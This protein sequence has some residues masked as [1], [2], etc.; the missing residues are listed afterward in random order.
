MLISVVIYFS[1]DM[2]IVHSFAATGYILKG[3]VF[4]RP[5]HR[6]AEVTLAGVV[7]SG[8]S[9][10]ADS[11]GFGHELGPL[12]SGPPRGPWDPCQGRD[13]HFLGEFSSEA[14]VHS[15]FMND[16]THGFFHS[17]FVHDCRNSIEFSQSTGAERTRSCYAN[18]RRRPAR[19]STGCA[20]WPSPHT[21]TTILV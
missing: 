4:Q 2:L 3:S 10:A 9:Q 21:T 16:L 19:C 5:H 20:M 17:C 15:S 18:A 14:Q 13:H 11:S 8:S 12:G 6:L 7:L 1:C